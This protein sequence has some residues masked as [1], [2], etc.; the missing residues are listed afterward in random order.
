MHSNEN[1]LAAA[2]TLLQGMAAKLQSYSASIGS[3]NQLLYLNY[4]LPAQDAF[5]SYGK[6]NVDLIRHV[7]AQYDPHGKLQTRVPGGFKI[8]RVKV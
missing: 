1:G 6:E 7:A 4:A 3:Q 5:G 8:L 2:Q